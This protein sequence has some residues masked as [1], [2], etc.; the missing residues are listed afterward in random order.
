MRSSIWPGGKVQEVRVTMAQLEDQLG[1]DF[2]KIH[3]STLV[4]VRAIHNVT[5]TVNLSNGETLNYVS[6]K[7]PIYSRSFGTGRRHCFAPCRRKTA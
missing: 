5:D 7:S 2:L 3:R 1:P 4:S 6:N